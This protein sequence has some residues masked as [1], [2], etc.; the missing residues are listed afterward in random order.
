MESNTEIKEDGAP[1]GFVNKKELPAKNQKAHLKY[2]KKKKNKINNASDQ[3]ALPDYNNISNASESSIHIPVIS[4]SV[5]SSIDKDYK[6]K[7]TKYISDFKDIPICKLTIDNYKKDCNS[8]SHIRYGDNIDGCILL[9]DINVV[10][11]IA[12]ETKNNGQKW[13]QALEVT[14]SYRGYKLSAQ[15]LNLAIKHFG[16]NYLSVN[17]DNQIAI[18]LYNDNGFIEYESNNT[19]IFMKRNILIKERSLLESITD[20]MKPI[21][22]VNSFTNT[23]FGKVI[24]VWT[25]SE[26]S[27]TAMSFDT[28]LQDL[29][30]FNAYNGVRKLGGISKETIDSYIKVYKD[31]T[32]NVRCV[33]VKDSDLETVQK[34]LDKMMTEKT[35]TTYGYG[36]IFNIL[37]GKAKEMSD[38]AMSMVC[39]QFVAYILRRADI[40]IM[41]K[42]INLI[43]PSDFATVNNP[44]MYLLYSGLAR[45]YD[46]KKIDRVFRKL[47]SKALL[48]KE[49]LMI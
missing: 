17:R 20:D 15:L 33:F 23:A 32:I 7:G 39:S 2:L 30:S 49:S 48:I 8:L 19:M 27:H 34:V 46:K 45:E 10:G 25:H 41:D 14:E 1:I 28:G 3:K 26:Y 40:N 12:V 6:S 42:S 11:Y 47:K 16:A 37:L 21:F 31:A 9:D 18:K 36:N 38:D 4:E 43:T 5:I 44:R 24:T 29:Y 22:I 35:N 13:I